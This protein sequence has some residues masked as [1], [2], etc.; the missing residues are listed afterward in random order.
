MTALWLSRTFQGKLSPRRSFKWVLAVFIKVSHT[1][2]RPQSPISLLL[3]QVRQ[4]RICLLARNWREIDAHEGTPGTWL[5]RK[6]RPAMV[7]SKVQS[8]RRTEAISKAI[9]SDASK[10]QPRSAWQLAAL[11]QGFAPRSCLAQFSNVVVKKTLDP[12]GKPPQPTPKSQ[13]CFHFQLKEDCDNSKWNPIGIH[14]RTQQIH[15]R[16]ASS[17]RN[18]TV[19]HSFTRNRPPKPQPL[20]RGNLHQRSREG[21]RTA[22]KKH[23]LR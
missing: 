19:V 20:V 15:R 21:W 22:R 18:H 2:C 10:V 8:F 11:F 9:R 17:H 7:P 4:S 16:R 5:E 13:C 1:A 14:K 6:R 3:T 12:W 23:R